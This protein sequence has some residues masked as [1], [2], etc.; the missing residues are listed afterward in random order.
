M[1]QVEHRWTAVRVLAL[2]IRAARQHL[3]VA[4][5][6]L[7]RWL[8]VP[9]TRHSLEHSG[10]VLPTIRPR[11]AAEATAEPGSRE[12][13]NA[14]SPTVPARSSGQ[15]ELRHQAPADSGSRGPRRPL[16]VTAAVRY[17]C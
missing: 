1:P 16:R 4:R 14:R 5:L 17:P 8:L 11:T 13:G 9:D 6:D 3:Q 15:P 7:P 2:A 10:R 12:T